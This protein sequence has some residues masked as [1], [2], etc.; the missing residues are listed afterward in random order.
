MYKYPWSRGF[1]SQNNEYS[2]DIKNVSGR[3]P[4]WLNGTLYRNG[5][6]KNDLNGQWF[7]HWFDGDGMISSF[8]F[9]DGNIFYQNKFIKTQSYLN[10]K[11]SNRILTR[12]FGKMRPGG[13]LENIFRYPANVSNTSVLMTDFGLLSLWEGGAPYRIDPDTLDTLDIYDFEGSASVFSAHPKIDPDNGVIYNFGIEYGAFGAS[14]SL[15]E[16]DGKEFKVKGKIALPHAY[17]NHDFILTKNYMVFCFGPILLHSTTMMLGLDSFDSALYWK[18]DIPTKILLV[19]R[20]DLKNRWIEADPFFQF[21]FANGFEDGDHVII[22]LIKYP[23]YNQIGQAFREFWHTDWPSNNLGK[24]NR[25]SINLKNDD[26]S[27]ISYDTGTTNEFPHVDTR[28]TGTSYKFSY[29]VSNPDNCLYGWVQRLT[30][31]NMESG[32]VVSRQFDQ[33]EFPGEALFVPSSP[34]ATAEDGIVLVMLYNAND[35]ITELVGL[36]PEKINGEYLFKAKLNHHV[37]IPL[38]GIFVPQR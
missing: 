4:S 23:T 38:H 33:N 36:N 20:N 13:V 30:R 5:P 25:M 16:I 27:F 29:I 32:E 31:V 24:L 8:R 7:P 6:A 17:M 19:S 37:P 18:K 22:D 12:G 11:K 10:E 26:V 21:H 15:Y 9:Q 3:V 28:S 34:T 1:S 2:Y 35:H 14:L